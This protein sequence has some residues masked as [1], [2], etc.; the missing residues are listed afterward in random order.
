MLRTVTTK[1]VQL[2]AE[3]DISSVFASLS[4]AAPTPLPARFAQIKR[5]LV[6]GNERQVTASWHRLLQQLR[7][8]NKIVAAAG[9]AIIPQIEFSELAT[10]SDAVKAEIRKRGV[11]VIKS[12]IP[13]EE[14]R[15]YKDDVEKYVKANPSTKGAF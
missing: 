12:V 5:D 4:G 8:E 9:P 3:G 7:K 1:T 2:K 15:S 13:E 14:A 6:K 10:A 11:A